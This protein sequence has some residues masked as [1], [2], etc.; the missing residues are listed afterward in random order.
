MFL[1]CL[2]LD[3]TVIDLM[4]IV[5]MEKRVAWVPQALLRREEPRSPAK[6]G[7]K[8]Q[9]ILKCRRPGEGGLQ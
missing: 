9:K 6:N 1:D 2:F 4:F 3:L 5:H 8:L 7:S